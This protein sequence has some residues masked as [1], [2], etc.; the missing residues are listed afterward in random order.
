MRF[1]VVRA[2]V[3]RGEKGEE[4]FC[5]VKGSSMAARLHAEGTSQ[6][7]VPSQSKNLARFGQ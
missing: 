4:W 1:E 6:T 2:I 7:A 3:L 5:G